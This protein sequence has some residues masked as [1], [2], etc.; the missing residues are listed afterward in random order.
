VVVD[1]QWLLD[2]TLNQANKEEWPRS[3]RVGPLAI[4]LPEKFW[5]EHGSILIKTNNCTVRFSPHPHQTGFRNAGDARPS[6][7]RPL[8]DLIFETAGIN[9]QLH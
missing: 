6:H 4:Q 1:N 2:A 9:F 3:M 5:A 7:W 8:A